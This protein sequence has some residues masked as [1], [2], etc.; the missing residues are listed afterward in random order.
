MRKLRVEFGDE[1][2]FTWIMGGLAR[3][4]SGGPEAHARLVLHWLDVGEESGMPIDP[5]LWRDGPIG[6]TYPACMAAKAAGEQ[7]EAAAE[8]Y[9]R[10]LR[11][12][13]FC[14][15]R[16]LDT[17]EP[18]VEEARTAGLDVERFRIDLRSNAIVEAFG[19]D[20][21]LTR[22]APEGDGHERLPLPAAVFVSEQGERHALL[23]PASYE[24]HRAAAEAA[25][26]R[27]SG[28]PP[29]GVLDA[30]RRFGRMA[31]REVE[32]VCGLPGPV[33]AAELW[34]LAREWRVR[35]VPVLTGHLWEPA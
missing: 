20:L 28:D 10:A 2:R 34:S 17:T 16:K 15:R 4:Y 31:T 33:A 18:L 32:L 13:L 14:F 22:D 29:P 9:L 21:D 1:L 5:R 19:R 24:E 12:G 3:E 11:E 26:A 35:P 27:P 23:G 8:R 6:S 30:L 7:G 25:G